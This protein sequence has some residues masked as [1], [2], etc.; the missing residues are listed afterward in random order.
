MRLVMRMTLT[1][2]ALHVRLLSLSLFDAQASATDKAPVAQPAQAATDNDDDASALARLTDYVFD[3]WKQAFHLFDDEQNV[4][5]NA[6]GLVGGGDIR[7]TLLKSGLDTKALAT[8]WMEIDEER[9]GA[10]GHLVCC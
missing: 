9:R 7:P 10:V 6:E 1:H 2:V 3:V 8:I 5:H 4:K